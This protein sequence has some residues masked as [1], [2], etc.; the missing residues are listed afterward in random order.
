M[1]WS[2]PE[3]THFAHKEE[4]TEL[5]DSGFYE[6]CALTGLKKAPSDPNSSVRNVMSRT[7]HHSMNSK[8]YLSSN[9]MSNFLTE[10]STRL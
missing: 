3:G 5:M 7:R 1:N 8:T 6:H 4:L 2:G 9:A 10:L